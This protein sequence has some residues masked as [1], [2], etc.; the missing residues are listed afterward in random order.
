MVFYFGRKFLFFLRHMFFEEG[1]HFSV[2]VKRFFIFWIENIVNVLGAIVFIFA[3]FSKIHFAIGA[4]F[5]QFGKCA[6]CHISQKVLT[7][8]YQGAW[9]HRAWGGRIEVESL[10]IGAFFIAFS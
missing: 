8:A 7:S 1:Y 5:L 4:L 6:L 2:Y 3:F 10:E 9:H